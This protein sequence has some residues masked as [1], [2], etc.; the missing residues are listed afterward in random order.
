MIRKQWNCL[1]CWECIWEFTSKVP[2]SAININKAKSRGL[3]AYCRQNIGKD[4]KLGKQKVILWRNVKSILNSMF[5]YWGSLFI[6]PK[7]FVENVENTQSA[8]LWA[9]TDLKNN[10]A[11]ISRE[12]VCMPIKVGGLGLVDSRVWNK[13]L[14]M[15]HI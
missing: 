15:R 1:T 7:L 12:E 8:V 10:H 3:S 13:V 4:Q 2:R 11:K 14:T 9:G 5:V 6:L